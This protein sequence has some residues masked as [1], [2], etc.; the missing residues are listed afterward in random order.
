MKPFKHPPEG[1]GFIISPKDLA[2]KES[3]S[4]QLS[5]DLECFTLLKTKDG[6][7]LIFCDRPDSDTWKSFAEEYGR[8]I[9]GKAYRFWQGLTFQARDWG[10]S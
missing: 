6:A 3:T 10:L 8:E 1:T 5:E 9:V 2:I 4:K 7:D